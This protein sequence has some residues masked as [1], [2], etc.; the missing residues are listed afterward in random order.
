KEAGNDV[1]QQVKT[2]FQLA[3]NHPVDDKSLRAL[4]KLYNMAFEQFKTD[5]DKT[6]EMLGGM[7]ARTNAETAALAVVANVILNLDEVVTKN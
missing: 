7:S 5:P 6:C 3:T 2:G 4:V 1:R